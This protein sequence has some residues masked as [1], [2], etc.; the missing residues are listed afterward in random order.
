MMETIFKIILCHLIGDY[1]LQV[2]FI[3]NTKGSNWY[4]LIV[5]CILYIFPFYVLFGF[6]WKLLPLFLSHIIIDALKARWGKIGYPMDQFL[7]YEV[8]FVLY[9]MCVR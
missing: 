3:A 9:I 7:H 6:D 2:D 8:A 1:F 5:H 4:H